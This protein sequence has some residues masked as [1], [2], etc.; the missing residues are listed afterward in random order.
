MPDN[1][2]DFWEYVSDTGELFFGGHL[3]ATGYSGYGEGK[4]NPAKQDTRRVGPIPAGEWEIVGPPYDS[5]KVGPFV[6]RLEPVDGTQTFGRS[7]FLIHGDS[8]SY[9]GTASRGCIIL[10]R[11]VRRVIWESGVRRLK[12]VTHK[13]IRPQGEPRM[14][15]KETVKRVAKK[16]V[17]AVN[18]RV[19]QSWKSTLIGIGVSAAIVVL[20]TVVLELQGVESTAAKVVAGI[21]AI[22]LMSLRSKKLPQPPEPV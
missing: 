12:V 10:S 5:P 7:A 18:E 4:N 16:S 21:I 11:P 6:L 8:L 9:P 20:D 3:F 1:E 13:D 2:L 15:T 19:F 22:I 17:T 14:S